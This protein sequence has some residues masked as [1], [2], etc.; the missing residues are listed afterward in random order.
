MRV[1]GRASE[2]RSEGIEL[3]LMYLDSRVNASVEP[4][5]LHEYLRRFAKLLD[6]YF[7]LQTH[8]P[9]GVALPSLL[10]HSRSPHRQAAHTA[11]R[12][13]VL[14]AMMRRSQPLSVH[15]QRAGGGAKGMVKPILQDRCL[16]RSALYSCAYSAPWRRH[17]A[18]EASILFIPDGRSEAGAGRRVGRQVSTDRYASPSIAMHCQCRGT[19]CAEAVMTDV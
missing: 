9:A 5:A 6:A 3:K 13:A 17:S 1:L 8:D 16:V 10:A 18:G 7:G 15:P 19:F 11:C 12:A 2:A 14:T 4:A